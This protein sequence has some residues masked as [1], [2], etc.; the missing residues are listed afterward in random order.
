MCETQEATIGGN[1]AC[2][3]NSACDVSILTFIIHLITILPMVIY[4]LGSTVTHFIT[5]LII[6]LLLCLCVVF[7]C[8]VKHSVLLSEEMLHVLVM[9]VASKPLSQEMPRVLINQ[10]Q[11]LVVVR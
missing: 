1:A 10:Y 6:L 5:Y 2:S 11:L 7:V 3:L 4:S 8:C 9:S